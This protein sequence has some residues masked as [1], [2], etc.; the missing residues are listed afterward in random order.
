MGLVDT[1]SQI[2]A[3]TKRLST[4]MGL[5]IHPLGALLHLMG[6]GAFQYDTRDI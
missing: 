1:Q 4:E 2:A 3:L 5:R 6:M